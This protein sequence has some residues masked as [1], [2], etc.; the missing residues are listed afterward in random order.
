MD[1]PLLIVELVGFLSFLYMALRLLHVYRKL[2]TPELLQP[3][4]SFIFLS[5]SQLCAALSIVY[6]DIRV[7]TALYSATATMAMT[8]FFIM[9]LQKYQQKLVY[10]FTPFALL[11]MLPDLVA[12][13]LSTYV[14]INA[15]KHIRILL[16]MLSSSYYLRALSTVLGVSITPIILLLAE[17]VRC[18]S[19]VTLAMYS[20]FKVFRL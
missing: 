20:S 13:I 12:G 4:T 16:A 11:I 18:I 3:A 6:R 5:I 17:V 1:I 2:G 7:S 14:A 8:A 9:I 19:A 10:A 15:T